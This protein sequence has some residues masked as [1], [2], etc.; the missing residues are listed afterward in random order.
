MK[1]RFTYFALLCL[2]AF[3]GKSQDM[4]F[5][6][7]YMTPLM[8]NPALTGF[9]DGNYRISGI[10]RSQWKSVTTPYK[11]IGGALDWNFRSGF[12]NQD[13]Y[14]DGMNIMSDRAGDSHFTTTRVDLSTA[15]S[16]SLDNFNRGYLSA[17]IQASY[18]SAYI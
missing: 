11:T 16:K 7:F 14:G 3:Q 18:T 17:G 10:A 13:M 15:Y 1:Q 6:Q 2:I 5:S 8:Q 12:N 9:F 4:H